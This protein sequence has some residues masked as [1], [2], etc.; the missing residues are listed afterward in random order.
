[1][2]TIVRA[3]LS[4]AAVA[5]VVAL[6]PSAGAAP[7]YYD[8]EIAPCSHLFRAPL[9]PPRP[10]AAVYWSPFGTADIV[11]YDNGTGT[12]DFYQRDPMGAWHDMNELAPGHFFYSIFPT[13]VPDQAHW[14]AG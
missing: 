3:G 8:P 13:T 11:C 14:R 1:M 2:R 7:S 4:A 5:G 12:P 10:G 6:A 9:D